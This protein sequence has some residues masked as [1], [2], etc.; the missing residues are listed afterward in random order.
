[1][2]VVERVISQEQLTSYARISGDHNLLHLD[3]EFAATTQFGGII[4]HGMLTLAYV[5]EM[6]TIAFGGSWLGSGRLKVRFK[7]PAYLGD[8]VSTW[9]EVVK[10]ESTAK[11]RSIE[12]SVGLKNDR[13]EELIS[14]TAFITEYI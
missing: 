7:G 12:C 2:P 1:M 13:G 10:Q 6:L 4:A 3:A 8:R 9:G 5:S 11:E 14:G